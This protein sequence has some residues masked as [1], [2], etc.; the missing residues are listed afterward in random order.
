[1]KLRFALPALAP[2]VLLAACATTGAPAPSAGLRPSQDVAFGS[3]PPV[4]PYGLYLAGQ[5]A[6]NDADAG[7][8]SRYFARAEQSGLDG[9][10][11]REQAFIAAVMSGDIAR[12]ARLTPTDPETR[13]VIERLAALTQ[14]VAGIGEG[15]GKLALD[16]LASG[17]VNIPHRPAA[18]LLTPFAA[19]VAGDKVG[20]LARPDLRGDRLVEVFGQ[21]GQAQMFERG[22]RYDEAETDYMALMGIAGAEALFA[23]DY[24]AFLERRGR[25]ADAV[26]VYDKALAKAP[27]DTALVRARARAASRKAAPAMP[28]LREGAARGLVAQAAQMLGERQYEMAVAYFRMALYLDPQ[29]AEARVLMGD[30]MLANNDV[31]GARA[32]FAAVPAGAPQYTAART[33]LAWTYQQTKQ[34]ETALKLAREGFEAAPADDDT[35]IAYADLLRANGRNAE[36]VTV[37][38]GVIGRAGATPDWRLLYM[39]GV[40][41]ERVNR[42]PEAERDLRAALASEPNEPELLNFLGYSWIDRGERLAEALDMVKRAVA[43]SPQSGAV[44]DSL[45]WAYYRLGDYRNAVEQLEKAVL[46]EPADAEINNHLGDAYWRVGRRIEAEFQWKRVL[47]L[48]PPDKVRADAEAKLKGGLGPVGPVRTPVATAG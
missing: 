7:E 5:A 38:D 16:A 15:D 34:G 19:A 8:A 1:M 14:V 11:F 18:A 21:L 42:W 23:P 4:S 25:W 22:R 39:R 24:G 41:L 3:G 36:A 37:L 40:A 17:K 6:M 44:V 47:S 27:A 28:T 30:A 32:A 45:G 35:A 10:Y 48:D 31:E 2:L 9:A 26:A 12:A 46:L 13:P 33:K 29:R 20:A 43:A